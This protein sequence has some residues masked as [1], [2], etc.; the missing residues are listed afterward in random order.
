MGLLAAEHP[1]IGLIE[2]F[3]TP[4]WAGWLMAIAVALVSIPSVI[5][6]H[7]KKKLAPDLHNKILFADADMNKADWM[8]G[9]G[10]A[11]GIL[12]IGAGLWWADGAVAVLISFGIIS[13]G[14]GNLRNCLADLIDAR[15]TTYDSKDPHPLIAEIRR[16]LA[17]LDWVAEVGCRVRDQGHVL[18]SEVFVVPKNGEMPTLE[19]LQ[20]AREVGSELDWKLHDLVIAPVHEL[21][22]QLL[23]QHDEDSTEKSET[24][25][26]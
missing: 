17:K 25:K 20:D 10:T 18:H 16:E 21:P 9:F 22:E 3:G 11:I 15:A 23:P 26:S 2:I 14:L 8:T 7:I 12:G 19:Q 6:G 24:T 13:D 5:L 4:V 1:P